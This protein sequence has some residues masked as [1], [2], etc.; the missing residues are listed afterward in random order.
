MPNL[1]CSALLLI[2][3][4]L[5]L[6]GLHKEAVAGAPPLREQLSAAVAPHTWALAG[7]AQVLS[8]CRADTEDVLALRLAD[9]LLACHPPSSVPLLRHGLLRAVQELTPPH[10]DDHAEEEAEGAAP[11]PPQDGDDDAQQ[12]TG[13]ARRES[14]GSARRRTIFAGLASYDRD[15]HLGTSS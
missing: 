6:E 10:H 14:R 13:V 9:A 15:S 12:R 7:V 11:P 1:G 4:V 5:L 8:D 3:I 2:L